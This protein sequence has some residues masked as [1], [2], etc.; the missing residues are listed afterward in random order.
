MIPLS[1]RMRPV[2]MEDV[3][4]QEHF[5]RK[6]SLLYNSVKRGTFDS[7]IFF[8]PSGTGKTTLARI[9]CKELDPYYVEINSATT[10]TKE[11]KEAL[12]HAQVRFYGLESVPT[13]LYIDEIHRWNKLQQD[14]LLKALE[15]GFIRIVG[16]TTE[17]PFFSIN[18][19]IL[20][21]VSHI[22]EFH[23]LDEDSVFALL[24]K[25][26]EDERIGLGKLN[27]KWDEVA[28]RLLAKMS[29]G[30]TRS[31]LDT[32][33]FIVEN[34]DEPRTITEDVVCEAKQ[35]PNHF[36]NKEDDKYDLLSALQKSIR[37]SDPNASVYYLGRL[38][39]GG[40]DLMTICRRLLVIA[41]ED[42]GLA[43]PSAISIVNS[44]VDAAIKV[45]F[46]EARIIL[47]QAVVLMASSPKSNRSYL[48]IGE[49]LAYIEENGND[50]IPNH[51][52][53]SHYKGS[54]RL[55]YGKTYKYPHSYGGYVQQQYL[56]DKPYEDGIIFYEPTENGNEKSFKR[57]LENLGDDE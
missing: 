47:A 18:N 52:R 56:P 51:L 35:V 23:S 11:L 31:A 15:E 22:Y 12:E 8:G 3:I 48:A 34:L 55:G 29:N 2:N 27:V 53:D 50:P 57:Y 24:V 1:T 26:L 36:Y 33:G 25:A 39:K 49:A 41:S 45:G 44:C 16:T 46:P 20:S 37:G 13:Y 10:G 38:I 43:Y 42:I 32:L 6:G 9:I 7:A 4:G 30:D 19:A 14:S 17:N 5:W 40:A 54:Q 28:I 21:R